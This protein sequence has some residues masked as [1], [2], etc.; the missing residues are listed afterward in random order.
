[1]L[2]MR[3]IALL[4]TLIMAAALPAGADDPFCAP[5]KPPVKPAPQDEPCPACEPKVCDKCTKSPVYV[6]AG[7]F[8]D[9]QT[10]LAIRSE[11]RVS[12]RLS[13]QDR[14]L[15]EE[16]N[17]RVPVAVHCGAQSTRDMNLI[18]SFGFRSEATAP[19]A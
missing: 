7:T 1:M 9:A 19:R 6:G 13:K 8:T 5:P 18:F 10:D 3:T 2:T 4:L 12:M 15:I 16:A 11:H 14:E 17:G